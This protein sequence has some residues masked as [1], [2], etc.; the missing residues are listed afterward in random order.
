MTSPRLLKAGIVLIDSVT[1]AVRKVIALQYN[2]DTLSRS[3]SIRGM[4]GEG[5]R[6]EAQRLTGPPVETLKLDAEMDA[7]D[8][9]EFPDRNPNAVALGIQPQL[10]ALEMLIYPSSADIRNE[11]SLLAVGTIEVAP[12]ETPL[13]LFVW[14][15]ERVVPVR[16]TELSIVEEAFDPNLNPIR[17]R[18]SLSMRVLSVNDLPVDH[19]G[20][21][22]YMSYQQQKEKLARLG[23]AASLDSLGITS[24]L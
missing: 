8:Q 2:P 12:A 20:A 16:L 1:A 6:S 24:I 13:M 22:I 4:S 9:L 7:T 5:E 15:K 23:P 18:V 3:F 19:R 21:A 10:A 11:N 17:A 14:S